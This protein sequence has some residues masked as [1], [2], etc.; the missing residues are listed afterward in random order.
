LYPGIEHT[1]I[2]STEPLSGK[3]YYLFRG[4]S[5][6][7]NIKNV[8]APIADVVIKSGYSFVSLKRDVPVE[9]RSWELSAYMALDGSSG[10][11]SGT[12]DG[13]LDDEPVFGI[14]PGMELKRLVNDNVLSVNDL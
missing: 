13:M 6:D 8:G 2:L 7:K 9:G 3:S 11:Y 14:V 5:I 1:V 12:F 4:L 10:I